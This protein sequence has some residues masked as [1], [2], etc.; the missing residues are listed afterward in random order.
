MSDSHTIELDKAAR[1]AAIR[2]ALKQEYYVKY[3]NPFRI[4][5]AQPVLDSGLQRYMAARAKQHEFFKVSWPSLRFF[6]FG[7][8]QFVIFGYVCSKYRI[9]REG[10]LRRGEVAPRDRSDRWLY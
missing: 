1:R 7:V 2:S 10:K 4:V 8:S 9:K 3:F 5:H 6:M